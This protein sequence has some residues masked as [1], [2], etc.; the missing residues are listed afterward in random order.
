MSIDL[1]L[2][3]VR[4]DQRLEKTLARVTAYEAQAFASFTVVLRSCAWE[5]YQFARLSV[6]LPKNGRPVTHWRWRE[7]AYV[8]VVQAVCAAV[9]D[10]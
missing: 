10:A 8:E 4:S 1:L 7:A 5:D 9:A 2:A 6:A 3:L